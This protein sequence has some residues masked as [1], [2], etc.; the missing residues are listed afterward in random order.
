MVVRVV[1]VT[2]FSGQ[3]VV[4][5]QLYCRAEPRRCDDPA[6]L[7]VDPRRSD[8]LEDDA[9]LAPPLPVGGGDDL[10]VGLPDVLRV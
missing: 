6:L 2:L 5:A 10:Q 1:Q 4:Q 7:D 8:V 9:K 3:V